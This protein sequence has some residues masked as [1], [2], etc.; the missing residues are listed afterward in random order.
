MCTVIIHVARAAF[1]P[2][3]MLAIRDEDPARPWNPLGP[4][5]PDTHRRRGRGA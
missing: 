2:I 5:W 1:D 4:W 3:R